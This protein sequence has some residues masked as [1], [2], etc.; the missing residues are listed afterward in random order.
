MTVVTDPDATGRTST[1]PQRASPGKNGPT[2]GSAKPTKSV[3]KARATATG[4]T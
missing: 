4:S 1:S 2:T 3:A